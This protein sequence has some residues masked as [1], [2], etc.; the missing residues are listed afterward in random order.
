MP[1]FSPFV[2]PDLFAGY[3]SA[4]RSDA[5]HRRRCRLKIITSLLLPSPEEAWEPYCSRKP[6]LTLSLSLPCFS[7][8]VSLLLSPLCFYSRPAASS[9]FP[10]RLPP[11]PL[12]FS[13]YRVAHNVSR[14]C[15]RV[16]C[17]FDG[18]RSRVGN[19]FHER[20]LRRRMSRQTTMRSIFLYIGHVF[21]LSF[22]RTA[23][24]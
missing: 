16:L 20:I 10:P 24:A 11:A 13:I 12:R 7:L 5:R 3:P 6:S 21:S 19:R 1:I 2:D 18:T 8:S 22:S 15:R 17:Q 9:I 14:T 4:Y 23:T